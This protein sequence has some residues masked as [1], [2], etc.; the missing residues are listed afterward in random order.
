MARRLD[1]LVGSDQPNVDGSP[2]VPGLPGM[3][4]D[5]HAMMAEQKH[6][7]DTEGMVGQRLDALLM[8]MGEDKERQAAQ[9]NSELCG[10]P[11]HA[12]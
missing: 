5:V 6:R 11:K 8:M 7:N 4:A 12:H 9:M 1:T 3:M 2:P 10:R